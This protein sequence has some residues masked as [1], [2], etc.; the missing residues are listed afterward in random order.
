MES[1]DLLEAAD[2]L[3]CTTGHKPF[4]VYQVTPV[5]MVFEFFF[6]LVFKWH[7]VSVD[8]I[9]IKKKKSNIVVSR[10]RSLR[11]LNSKFIWCIFVVVVYL[12]LEAKFPWTNKIIQNVKPKLN[13]V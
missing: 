7:V 10:L 6:S 11:S 3:F 5:A 2:I 8:I 9:Q 4:E 13:S 1:E 12:F